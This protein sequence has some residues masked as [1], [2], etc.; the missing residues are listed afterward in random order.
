[1]WPLF[2]DS[3]CYLLVVFTE[4]CIPPATHSVVANERGC[5]FNGFEC[6]GW[7]DPGGWDVFFRA[8]ACEI[9]RWIHEFWGAFVFIKG[10]HISNQNARTCFR[11]LCFPN[12]AVAIWKMIHLTML[13]I[14]IST[15]GG[16]NSARVMV[17]WKSKELTIS[18]YE[19]VIDKYFHLSHPAFTLNQQSPEVFQVKI[20]VFFWW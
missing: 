17:S 15:M 5:L 1:M 18:P 4:K 6:L 2:L 19:I 14:F 13:Q 12:H 20:A 9:V 3:L 11:Y 7:G 16:W 8:L 10:L